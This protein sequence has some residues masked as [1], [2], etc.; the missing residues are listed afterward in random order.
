MGFNQSKNQFTLPINHRFNFRQ[1]MTLQ[2]KGTISGSNVSEIYL[3]FNQMKPIQLILMTMQIRINEKRIM[4][5][6]Q[7]LNGTWN[8]ELWSNKMPLK[9]NEDFVIEFEFP[10]FTN[11]PNDRH[12]VRVFINNQFVKVFQLGTFASSIDRLIFFSNDD[13]QLSVESIDWIK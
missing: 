11:D 6:N 12:T 13:T 9:H 10:Q 1:N 8:N 7:M 2:I 5:N 4:F 3:F